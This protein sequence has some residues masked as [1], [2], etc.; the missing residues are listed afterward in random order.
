MLAT[1]KDL[2]CFIQLTSCTIVNKYWTGGQDAK[3]T[4]KSSLCG[5]GILPVI[6]NFVRCDIQLI[7]CTILNYLFRNR[8]DACEARKSS[9][10]MGILPVIYNCAIS[11]FPPIKILSRGMG[12]ILTTL[13]LRNNLFAV[14]S[15]KIYVEISQFVDCGGVSKYQ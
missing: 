15:P 3:P 14:L 7:S 13:L 4:I 2:W 10:G 12:G 9:R 1:Q 8:Q 6:E 11:E 5:M